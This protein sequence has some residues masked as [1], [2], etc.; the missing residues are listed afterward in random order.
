[1]EII[2]NI[3]GGILMVGIWLVSLVVS[4]AVPVLIIAWGIQL[5]ESWQEPETTQTQ[6]VPR[7]ESDYQPQA[8]KLSSAE[9][10]AF[11]DGCANGDNNKYCVCIYNYLDE[12]LTNEEF[13]DTA[14]EGYQTGDIPSD[15]SDAIKACY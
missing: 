14:L 1:M 15:Y 11:M 12:T 2:K 3:G 5:Y 8:D 9:R 13:I 10:E 7:T 6:S 4:I